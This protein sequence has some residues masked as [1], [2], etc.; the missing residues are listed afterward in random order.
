LERIQ[1]DAIKTSKLENR[2]IVALQC[3]LRVASEIPQ[4]KR[5]ISAFMPSIVAIC[6]TKDFTERAEF[7]ELS[8]YIKV[9]ALDK[10][11]KVFT[12]C[13]EYCERHA[14]FNKDE[15]DEE[16]ASFSERFASLAKKLDAEIAN[17][18]TFEALH[19]KNN[20]SKEDGKAEVAVTETKGASTAKRRRVF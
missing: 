9:M 11:S 2:F 4:D 6:L 15:E 20:S 5:T 1:E 16:L 10:L 17:P 13:Y 18:G 3:L 19:R 7:K 8:I 12:V 14:R